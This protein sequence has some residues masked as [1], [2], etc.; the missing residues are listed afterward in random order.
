[1][2]TTRLV[3][4]GTVLENDILGAWVLGL[5][6]K[7]KDCCKTVL[8]LQSFFSGGTFNSID[9]TE[10]HT[11]VVPPPHTHTLYGKLRSSKVV[12]EKRSVRCVYYIQNAI[13]L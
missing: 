3:R 4:K 2:H 7:Y 12:A 9:W 8:F 5:W 13:K 1:M 6:P 11:E 10:P